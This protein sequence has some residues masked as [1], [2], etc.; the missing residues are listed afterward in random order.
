MTK[1]LTQEFKIEDITIRPY[2]GRFSSFSGSNTPIHYFS[3]WKG[4]DYKGEFLIASTRITRSL[5]HKA[6][7]EFYEQQSERYF[8]DPTR[9]IMI[10]EGS[11]WEYK[12]S[13]SN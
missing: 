6:F 12:A 9:E 7:V 4:D 1:P 3:V 11:G 5:M 2:C 8:G 10:G 13:A